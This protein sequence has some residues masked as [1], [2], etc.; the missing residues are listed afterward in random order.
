MDPR[1]RAY[2]DAAFSDWDSV[3]K[4]HK[5]EADKIVNDAYKQFQEVSKSGLSLETASKA[6]EVLADL[7]KKIASLASGAVSDI[8]DNHPQA[9]EKFGGSIQ[10]LQSMGEQ[11]GPEAKK[12]VDETWSKMKDILAGGFSAA[13]LEKAR[14]LIEERVQQVKKLGDDAWKK[15]MEEAKPYLDKNPKVQELIEK[16]TDAL[17]QGNLKE[18]FDKLRSAVESKDLGDL[19]KY[20]ND[21]ADKAKSKGADAAGAL[22]LDKYLKMVPQGEE[23]LPKLQQIGQIADKHKEEGEKLLKETVE[24]LKQ[25][26]EKKWQKA[27]DIVHDSSKKDIK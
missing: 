4:N 26:L 12:Q 9:K 6:Y 3:R 8:L 2:V 13:N 16:N 22:S 14:K 10:Q 17:K 5:D 25:V 11:Y 20:V 18:L 27:Q 15:G 19:E 23:V 7:S 1:G 24:E 21:A